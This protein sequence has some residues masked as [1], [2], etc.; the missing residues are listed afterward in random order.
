[1]NKYKLG[2]REVKEMELKNIRSNKKV[3]LKSFLR[4]WTLKNILNK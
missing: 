3:T 4:E 1:M 2:W